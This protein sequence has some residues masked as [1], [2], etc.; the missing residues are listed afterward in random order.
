MDLQ[1]LSFKS[2]VSNLRRQLESTYHTVREKFKL[3]LHRQKELYD[4]KVH[5]EP[6]KENDLVWVH[7]NVVPRGASKKLHKSWRGPYKVIKKLSDQNYRVQ[8]LRNRKKRVV[9]H[10]DRLKQY[11]SNR[12]WT[13]DAD[14]NNIPI[15]HNM[16]IVDP[17]DGDGETVAQQPQHSQ[18]ST[19]SRRY[20]QRERN[21][22][23]WLAPYVEH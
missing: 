2:H 8:D 23:D 12:V 22:P 9:I 7:S 19:T 16:E 11:Q 6:Y 15:G 20:P 17:D 3:K 1:V 5:G 13:P 4:H 21:R 18:Q 14:T 10:F